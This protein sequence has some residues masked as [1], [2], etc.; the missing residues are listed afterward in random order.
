M[1]IT[2]ANVE[3][4]AKRKGLELVEIDGIPEG[5]AWKEPD[6]TFTYTTPIE[7]YQ[8]TYTGRIITFKPL[9]DWQD[10]DAITYEQ[11]D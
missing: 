6:V 11:R 5:F 10:K 9:A 3:E 8:K 2:R 4:Y 1:K 7:K